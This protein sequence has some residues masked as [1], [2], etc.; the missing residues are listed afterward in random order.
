MSSSQV[1]LNFVTYDGTSATRPGKDEERLIFVREI[2]SFDR[3]FPRFGV[4]SAIYWCRPRK[5][6]VWAYWDGPRPAASLLGKNLYAW[7]SREKLIRR[8]VTEMS[9]GVLT[10][11]RIRKIESCIGEESSPTEKEYAAITALIWPDEKIAAPEAE[12]QS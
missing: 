12:E 1:V 10:E 4:M 7:R 5:G 6:D 2:A 9:G 3:T 8:E 11:E